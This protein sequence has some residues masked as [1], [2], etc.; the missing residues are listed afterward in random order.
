[1]KKIIILSGGM[2]ST[3]LLYDVVKTY[4]AKNV[5]ALSFNYG[6]RHNELELDC[7]K[8]SCKKLKVKYALLDIE[9]IMSSFNS[10]SALLVKSGKVIPKG[11]YENK[12]MKKTVVPFRNGIL[13]SLAAGF[14][15]ANKA[16]TVFYGAHAGDH[17]IY[18]DCRKDFTKTFSK[19][20]TLGTYNQIRIEAPYTKLDKYGILKIGAVLGVDYSKTHTCYNPKE[21]VSCGK[22]GS[23]QERLEAF[24]KIGDNDPLPYNSRKLLKKKSK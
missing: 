15:E 24:E 8:E 5:I 14:A 11:H 7:A 12:N 20:V 13:L 4:G 17:E 6:S 2:D 23:C 18:P 19:A 21:G 1:M 10:D 22:C 9:P 16:N 3:T